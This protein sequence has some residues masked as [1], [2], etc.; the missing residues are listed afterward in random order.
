ML[1]TVD[2]ESK[3][4]IFN[5]QAE[6][7]KSLSDPKRLRIIHEL[8]DSEKSVGDLTK[9]LGLKQSNTSQ[10]LAVLRKAGIVVPRRE[11]NTVY[12][13]LVS[14]RITEAC[15]LVREVIADQF[16]RNQ[17]LQLDKIIQ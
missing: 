10:H 5:L 7:C 1:N 3:T 14:P 2:D 11:S 9:S 13:G 8:R 12:Y 6:L 17:S 16:R 15:D 4:E